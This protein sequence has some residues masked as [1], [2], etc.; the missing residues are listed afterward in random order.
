MKARPPAAADVLADAPAYSAWVREGEALRDRRAAL[1][2]QTRAAQQAQQRADEAQAAAVAAAVRSGAAI[3][4]PP[5]PVDFRALN[6]AA[7]VQRTDEQAHRDRRA[8]VVAGV[9]DSVLAKLR[10]RER[11]R[12]EVLVSLGANLDQLADEARRDVAV[13]RDVLTCQDEVGRVY[14]RPSRSDRV[15]APDVLELIAA[16]T[17]GKSLLDPRAMPPRDLDREGMILVDHDHPWQRSREQPELRG[18]VER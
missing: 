3:P 13:V 11:S 12:Q 5:A 6:A 4:E 16:A 2:R 10:E 14:V 9:A 1:D 17:S 8:A 15:S 7:A 18:V